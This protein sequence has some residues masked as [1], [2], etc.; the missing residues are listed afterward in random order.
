MQGPN[1]LQVR[2]SRH[3]ELIVAKPVTVGLRGIDKADKRG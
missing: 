1:N 3:G 2:A